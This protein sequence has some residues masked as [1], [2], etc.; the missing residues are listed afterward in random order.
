[1][2]ELSAAQARRLVVVCQGLHRANPFGR[3]E[4][5]VLR[6]IDQLGYIQ[7]DTISVIKRAHQHTF[8]TRLP[9]FQDGELDQAQR[10]RKVFEYWSHAAAYLPMHDFRYCLPYMHAIASGQKHWRKP[11]KKMMAS[12]M[13]RIRQDGPARARDFDSPPKRPA[14]FWGGS[15][16]AKVALEQLFIEGELMVSHRDG[17]Q[18]VFDLTERV[19]PA[20]VDSTKP[21]SEE[22]YR[23]LILRTIRAQGIATE[24]EMGYLR[25]GI[26]AGLRDQLQAMLADGEIVSVQV[27]ENPNVYYSSQ[28]VLD[29][30]LSVRVAKKVHLLSPFDNLVIQ[31]KR[32]SQL[33]R[34]DY[35]IECYVTES[36][37]QHGY[38]CLPILFGDQFVGRLDPKADRQNRVLLVRNLVIEKTLADPER[39]ARE[40]SA[41][42]NLLAV[43]NDCETVSIEQCNVKK[44]AAAVKRHF[45]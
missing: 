13:R 7:I 37:R 11:D 4:A 24:A 28:D 16:P 30:A 17:F 40:L 10:D 23:Y 9:S 3:S 15:K 5:G 33:F 36:K 8:W 32:V 38:F 21:S 34:F 18:K 43:F 14:D 42:L 27:E 12:V 31:R 29:S 20:G 41:K 39:F 1:M 45:N 6:C 25:K 2:I 22:F 35:Q 44:I 26:K 19:L